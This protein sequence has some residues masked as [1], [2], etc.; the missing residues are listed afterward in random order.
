MVLGETCVFAMASVLFVGKPYEFW[1]MMGN[2]FDFWC[3]GILRILDQQYEPGE[4]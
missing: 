3:E 2:C 1:E 4:K